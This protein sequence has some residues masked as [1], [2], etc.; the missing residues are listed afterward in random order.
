MKRSIR[1]E[2]ISLVLIFLTTIYLLI[3][4]ITLSFVNGN[5]ITGIILVVGFMAYLIY[6]LTLFLGEG[7]NGEE[8]D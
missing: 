8:K 2:I 5:V 6:L 7:T 4:S 3:N 1:W